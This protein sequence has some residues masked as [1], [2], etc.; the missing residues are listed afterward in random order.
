M[1]SFLAY[2]F[3]FVL[4]SLVGFTEA[5]AQFSV[6][7]PQPM[8]FE[9]Y[10]G[11]GGAT[12]LGNNIS[13]ED[14]RSVMPDSELLGR[15][16][17]GFSRRSDN[18][19]GAGNVA[20]GATFNPFLKDDGSRKNIK[21]RVGFTRLNSE[22]HGFS[23]NRNDRTPIDTL[24]S[25][26]SGRTL[27]VDSVRQQNFSAGLGAQHYYLDLGVQFDSNW[28]SRWQGYVGANVS[29][30]IMLAREANVSFSDWHYTDFADER[31]DNRNYRSEEEV[32]SLS[33]AFGF[34]AGIS[35]GIAWQLASEHPF[36]SK[37]SLF[38]EWRPSMHI[39]QAP[40]FGTYVT[41]ISL[42]HFGVRIR[43]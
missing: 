5:G 43:A 31:F 4:V 33:N 41:P 13:V 6:G 11:G 34:M 15:E 24:E 29:L 26:T 16:Y 30:G 22:S 7:N 28:N 18:Y 12:T 14:M 38:G 21:L 32:R 17:P 40:E 19:Y 42:S 2:S 23:F 27:V 10:L 37:V 39:S 3:S 35:A 36:W 25:A 8:K 9:F 20:V 1:R